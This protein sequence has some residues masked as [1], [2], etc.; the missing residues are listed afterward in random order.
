[1]LATKMRATHK[2]IMPTSSLG[3]RAS[4]DERRLAKRE[5]LS[6][7]AR[8]SSLVVKIAKSPLIS[9]VRAVPGERLQCLRRFDGPLQHRNHRKAEGQSASSEQFGFELV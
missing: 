8:L 1:M 9:S 5:A 7:A 4:R 3:A 2:I 6:V